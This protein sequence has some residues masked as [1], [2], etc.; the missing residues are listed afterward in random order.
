[1]QKIVNVR[2]CSFEFDF[3]YN[4]DD[5]E[6]FKNKGNIDAEVFIEIETEDGIVTTKHKLDLKDI[7]FSDFMQ[8]SDIQNIVKTTDS[9]AEYIQILRKVIMLKV[10]SELNMEVADVDYT[11]TQTLRE[12]TEELEQA[13]LET[14]NIAAMQE[15]RLQESEQAIVELSMLLNERGNE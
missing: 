1:M 10:A 3:G 13:L 14:T 4:P 15:Q 6:T 5:E 11:P 7:S 12:K 8:E 9:L 2:F